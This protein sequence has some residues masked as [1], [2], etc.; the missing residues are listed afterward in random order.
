MT[1]LQGCKGILWGYEKL[2]IFTMHLPFGRIV[3]G[4]PGR[5]WMAVY[6]IFL[7]LGCIVGLKRMKANAISVG[8]DDVKMLYAENRMKRKNEKG[9]RRKQDAYGRRKKKGRGPARA[10]TAI[11]VISFC[12]ICGAGHGRAGEIRIT[13]LDVGQGD[14]LYVRTPSNL[15]CLID[16]GSTDISKAGT[17]RI[18]PFLKSQGAGRLDYVFISHGDAD[19]IN[20][21][22][23]L[24][25]NQRMGISIDTLV[26]PIE[27]VWDDGMKG[28]TRTA[29]QH[30][31][32]VA[33]IREGQQVADGEMSFTCLAPAQDYI[34]EI[35][36]ASSMVLSLKYGEFDMLFTGDVEGA[37]EETLA[38]SSLLKDCDVLKVAHHGSKNSGIPQFLEAVLPDISLISA[39]RDNRYGHPHAETIERL[40]ELGS[41]IY[42]TQTCGAVTIRTDGKKI[43]IETFIGG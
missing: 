6:Y 35:G 9:G 19:H 30:G 3:P 33:V 8:S 12:M 21:I 18:E 38:R 37:G 20:G 13:M 14:S 41:Q 25:E 5:G 39:G 40:E 11:L 10:A 1:V 28:L 34:G 15:H 22:Q 31:T 2:C 32:R 42:S 7:F 4:Q 29:L 36:N 27:N 24:L 43:W 26:L 16:G 17:Y 23:E